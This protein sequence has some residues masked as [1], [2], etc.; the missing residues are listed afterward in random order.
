[1]RRILLLLTAIFSLYATAAQADPVVRSAT[2]PSPAVIQATVDQFRLDLGNPN[3]G[4]GGTFETG[5]REINWDGVLSQFASPAAFPGDFFNVSAPRG[6]VVTT[7]GSGFRVSRTAAQG[8]VRFGDIEPSYAD[9]FQTFSPQR[10]I[11]PVGSTITDVEFFVPGKSERLGVKGFGAIFSDVDV[12]ASSKIQWFDAAGNLLLERDVPATAISGGLSFLGATFDGA[13]SVARVRITSGSKP[14]AAGAVD[15]GGGDVV[16]L[17]DFIYGEPRDGDGVALQDNCPAVPNPDQGNAD[18]DAQGDACD[19]DDDNDGVVDAD[20]AFPLDASRSTAP[21]DT[22]SGPAGG[23]TAP[24]PPA[25]EANVAPVVSKLG[26]K[27]ARK[28]FK[29][30]YALSETARVAFTAEKKGRDGRFRRVKGGFSKAGR[31]GANA[32]RFSGRINRKTLRPG[33]YRLVA[34]AVDPSNERS[35]RVRRGFKVPR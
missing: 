17:D 16:V 8:Q 3:N 12:T 24:T 5:R 29:V 22:G 13:A 10:L 14:I 1:M 6:L 25:G 11:S 33:T 28:G 32:F 27:R 9:S 19:A 23:E 30:S 15:G 18:G 31:P 7:P 20:D 35:A 4:V 2:G 26:V 21:A 34:V